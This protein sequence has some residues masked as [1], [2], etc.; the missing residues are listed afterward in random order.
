VSSRKQ[1]AAPTIGKHTQRATAAHEGFVDG[2]QVMV[3]FSPEIAKD[4]RE[5]EEKLRF[6]NV[7]FDKAMPTDE[8]LTYDTVRAFGSGRPITLSH[9]V[10]QLPGV[11]TT[12]NEYTRK[13]GDRELSM[14]LDGIKDKLVDD[15]GNVF[16]SV[17]PQKSPKK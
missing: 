12:I 4:F 1:G 5:L 13:T 17:G 2:S 9:L 3:T 14:I 15:K 6:K 10:W 7:E 16:A 8:L 11:I